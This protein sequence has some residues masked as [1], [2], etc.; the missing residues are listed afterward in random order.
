[1]ANKKR[2]IN[3][4]RKQLGRY[5]L[6]R[7]DILALEKLLWR[8]A[9]AREMKHAG[10][11]DLPANRKHMPRKFVDRYASVGSYRPF[12]FSLGWNEFGVHYAGVD[13]MYR[14]DSVKFLSRHRHLKRTRYMELA[15]WPGIKITFTPL[16]TT[17][18][19]QTQYATGRE[20]RVMRETVELIEQY[21]SK[22]PLARLNMCKLVQ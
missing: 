17:V 1:M 7:S 9:D 14:E 20:L 3:G 8:Y 13:W 5:K 22:L 18:Y 2:D 15:A 12:H 16:S 11:T 6:N 21:L 19:A 4:Y 10:V